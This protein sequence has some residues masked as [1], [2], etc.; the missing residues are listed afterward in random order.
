MKT[1]IRSDVMLRIILAILL[2][3]V[4][5]SVTFTSTFARYITV[6]SGSDGARIAR[7]GV[8]VTAVGETFSTS[9]SGADIAAATSSTTEK[10]VAPGTHGKLSEIRVGGIP[11]VATK[12]TFYANL[13][14]TNWVLAGG[15]EYCPLVFTIDGKDYK[16]GADGI[17]NVAEL[18][19][20]VE[21]AFTSQTFERAPGFDLSHIND[22]LHVNEA[23][24]KWPHDIDDAK[25][26][27]LGNRAAAGIDVPTVTLEVNATVV[28]VDKFTQN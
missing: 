3:L 1:K 4:I 21:G 6:A 14:L 27:E 26:S 28:Q 24:W 7:W 2:T 9:Y 20:A 5:I 16:I 12:V 22:M 18:V 11:E 15:E 19:E 23:Y 10:I 25:D 17:D 13:D 8:T